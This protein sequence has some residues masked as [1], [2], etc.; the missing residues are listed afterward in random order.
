MTINPFS[1]LLGESE[2]PSWSGP[3]R[4]HE[5]DALA[6]TPPT[7][8]E[9]TELME[10]VSRNMASALDIDRLRVA[11]HAAW[12]QERQHAR[13][14]EHSQWLNHHLRVQK[15]RRLLLEV[16]RADADREILETRHASVA[17]DPDSFV[18][19]V[20]DRFFRWVP[21]QRA[22]YSKDQITNSKVSERYSESQGMMAEWTGLEPATPGVTG[23]RLK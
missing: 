5:L 1:Q 22:A 9:R 18:F 8:D 4:R 16:T 20:G 17:A 7:A 6:I 13:D 14:L 2:V 15:K 19:R 21:P 3:V 12:L 11:E 10:R 23:P